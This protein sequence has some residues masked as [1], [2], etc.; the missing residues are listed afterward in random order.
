MAGCLPCV[1][2][3]RATRRCKLR[4]A[5]GANT[6]RRTAAKSCKMD[7]LGFE[8][9]AFRMRSGCDTTTPCAQLVDDGA[10]ANQ[11]QTRT[12]ARSS[13]Q[14]GCERAQ[15]RSR[16]AL[17]HALSAAPRSGARVASPDEACVA[18]R[19]QTCKSAA[20]CSLSQPHPRAT[21]AQ[22]PSAQC[23]R[24]YAR[25]F[26]PAPK[27]CEA[28]ERVRREERGAAAVNGVVASSACSARAAVERAADANA[29]GAG[30]KR[31]RRRR[32][33][34]NNTPSQD[35]TGDLQRVR[36]TS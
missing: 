24:P 31:S 27:K 29:N 28:F 36:L 10:R 25:A 11:S 20:H 30:C 4:R 23:R 3:A 19:A 2:G 34:I 12:R 32:T 8:P 7:A 21:E 26:A 13:A 9:R 22:R 5:H 14:R 17:W 15:P 16:D 6:A 18:V 1:G 33:P 35:R